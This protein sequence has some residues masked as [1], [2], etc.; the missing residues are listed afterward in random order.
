MLYFA[1]A[2]NLSKNHMLSRC[3]ESKP[4][5]KVILRD[6]SLV[7]N[8]LADIIPQENGLVLGAMYVVSKQEIEELDKLEGYPDLY[9]RKIVEVEDEKGNKYDAVAYTM[10]EKD[11]ELPPDHY[12]E[13]LLEGYEDWDIPKEHLERAKNRE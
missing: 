11:F 9:D 13:I 12:Y 1:Y 4:I 7:F 10:V 2:S 3:P 5:K 6:Y 8:Q